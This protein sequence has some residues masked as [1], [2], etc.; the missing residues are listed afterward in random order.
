MEKPLSWSA[1]GRSV[2]K[3]N[4]RQLC[5]CGA[6]PLWRSRLFNVYTLFA[7][8]LGVWHTTES[9]LSCY[10]SW[11]DMEQST[12][13]LMATFNIGGSTVKMALFVLHRQQYNSL[14]RHADVLMT[15]GAP[16]SKEAALP[17]LVLAAQRRA[18]RL[19]LAMLMLIA[20]QY[21]TWFPMPL[22]VNRAE[23]R[24]PL[25]QHQWDDNRHFYALSYALQCMA[26]AWTTQFSLGVDC[27]FVTVMMLV[28]AQLEAL[29]SRIQGIR[30]EQGASSCAAQTTKKVS[31]QMYEELCLC[32]EVHQ[33]LLS[34]VKQL[35]STMSPIVTTQ[36]AI[37]VLVACVSLFPATY[38]TNFTAV[39][40]CA[41]FLPVPLGQLYLYCWAAHNVTQQAEAVSSAAYNCSWVGASERFKRALRI[42]ISR[43]QKP[44]VLTAGHLYPI[45]R[46]AFVSLLNASYSYYALLGQINSRS[47]ETTH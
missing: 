18:A 10:F 32:V 19:T 34:F 39:F 46:A 26:A 41:G 38:G 6:W 17:E 1:S 4:I 15:E 12:M 7:V 28:I 23:H 35:E 3:L 11:G 14:V 24:L 13:V 30:I 36:F 5:L 22:V 47:T 37:S 40:L 20:S 16:C 44:L 2:L 43:A 9:A 29:A 42:L 21:V 27:L 31:D 8:A 33:K 45:N 25:A